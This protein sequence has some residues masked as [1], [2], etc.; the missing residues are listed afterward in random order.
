MESLHSLK[1]AEALDL[2][3]WLDP[4]WITYSSLVNQSLHSSHS[5]FGT[6]FVLVCFRSLLFLPS[7]CVPVPFSFLG[8]FLLTYNFLI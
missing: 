3:S 2:S 5:F 6:S 4:S 1:V 8:H 7:L